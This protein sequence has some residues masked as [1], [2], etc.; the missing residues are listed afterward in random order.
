MVRLASVN[1]RILVELRYAT[2][3]NF[4]GQVIYTRADAWLRAATASKLDQ[5]QAECGRLGLRLKVLDAYRPPSAQRRLWAARPDPRFV[6]PPERGSRHTRG[7]AVD[8][9]LVDLAGRELEMP[10][11]YDEFTE[12]SHRSW[13]AGPPGAL[14]NR[15]LLTGFMLRQG[16]STISTEWW[17]FD[18]ANWQDY[19]LLTVE[20]EDLDNEARPVAS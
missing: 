5:A 7:T 16:F 3:R 1:S 4:T 18:D 10:S 20:F 14:A 6:A 9:T 15:Q 17:H 11:L 2:T 8:V 19:P 12:R 13:T